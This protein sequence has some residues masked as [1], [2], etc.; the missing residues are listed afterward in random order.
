MD[1]TTRSAKEKPYIPQIKAASV[2]C[3]IDPV[4][5]TIY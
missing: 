2:G 4:F 3:V 1:S 5:D